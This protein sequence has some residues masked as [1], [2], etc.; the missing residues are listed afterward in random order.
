[1]PSVVLANDHGA[2]ELAKRLVGYLE[3][4]GYTVNHLGVTSNDSVDYPDIAKEAS[5][6]TRKVSM[7][8]VS[9]S[10]APALEFPSVQIRLKESAVHSPPRTLMQQQWQDAITMQTSLHLGGENRLP[11]R[12]PRRYA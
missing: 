6:S 7:N 8:L 11:G 12:P 1:M 4:M 10:A 3:K 5:W 9:S 2:V